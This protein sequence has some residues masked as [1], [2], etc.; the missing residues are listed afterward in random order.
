MQMLPYLEL[1]KFRYHLNF[2]TVVFAALIFAVDINSR[3]LRS[4]LELYASFSV[5]FYTGIYTMNDLRDLEADS[6]HPLKKSRPLP[7]GRVSVKAASYLVPVLII[8][9][10]A[11]AFLL[12]GA[13]MLRLYAM[14]LVLNL[15]YSL[16]ARNVPYL[17][18]IVNS[19]THPIRFAMGV[20]LTGRAVPLLHLAAY[21]FFI[22]GFV[23]LRRD[24]EKDVPG[25][26]ARKTLKVYPAGTMRLLEA[27]SLL[28]LLLCCLAGRVHSKGFY[29]AIIATYVV[30]IL[31]AHLSPFVRGCL[32]AIWTQ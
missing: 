20:L 25:W 1:V 2:L 13:P 32:R 27:I 15:F 29:G 7:S 28:L 18:L 12:F 17:E 3:L 14:I 8:A 26:H 24:V 31:G 5:L 23:C 19:A 11:T 4:L 16:F 21:F 9:G 10:I 6:Q 22:F 30:V